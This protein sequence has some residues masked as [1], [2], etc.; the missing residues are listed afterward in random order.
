M[1]STGHMRTDRAGVEASSR[2][3]L[4]SHVRLRFDRAR[5]RHVLLGPEEVIVLNATGA[6]ILALCDGRRTVAQIEA[7]LAERY[8]HVADG[9]VVRFLA[10][11]V[12]KRC[13]EVE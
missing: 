8:D 10:R 5:D 13:V 6:D 12:A 11:L 1:Q 7:E 3:G 2:P 9:E 4:A